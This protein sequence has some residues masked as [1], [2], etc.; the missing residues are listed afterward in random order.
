MAVVYF[1]IVRSYKHIQ[2]RRGFKVFGAE[3]KTKACEEC[4]CDIP[5]AAQKC[6]TAP[7]SSLGRMKRQPSLL[8]RQ[9]RASREQHVLE[10]RAAQHLFRRTNE[11]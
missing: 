8:L 6:G 2:A 4:L 5:E 1:V 7:P 3:P 10:T 11:G 9:L